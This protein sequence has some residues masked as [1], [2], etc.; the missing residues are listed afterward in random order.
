M[1][2]VPPTC[3]VPCMSVCGTLHMRWHSTAPPKQPV[4]ERT[5]CRAP[6]KNTQ[7]PI[8]TT[9]TYRATQAVA[10]MVDTTWCRYYHCQQPPSYSCTMVYH[11]A[12]PSPPSPR[13]WDIGLK[14]GS[15]AIAW[16]SWCCSLQQHT[17]GALQTCRNLCNQQ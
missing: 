3:K 14:Q 4:A 9:T 12:E 13:N 1:Q 8:Q 2:H 7:Q 11:A 16:S 15:S 6:A 10:E 17:A 5:D